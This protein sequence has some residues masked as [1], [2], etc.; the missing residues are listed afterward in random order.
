[1]LAKH[2]F[3]ETIGALVF[4]TELHKNTFLLEDSPDYSL[5]ITKY[6]TFA[7]YYSPFVSHD[8]Q[9]PDAVR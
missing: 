2:F 5:C 8:S 4:C 7:K 6:R 9:H 3:L 1:M